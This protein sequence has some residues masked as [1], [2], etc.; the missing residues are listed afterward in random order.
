MSIYL[1]P[2]S[3]V[4]T[5]TPG[6][7]TFHFEVCVSKMLS[8]TASQHKG[9]GDVLWSGH[10]S[11]H[12]SK[13][14]NRSIWWRMYIYIESFIYINDDTTYRIYS[15]HQLDLEPTWASFSTEVWSMPCFVAVLQRSHQ[16]PCES[17]LVPM[18]SMERA[19]NTF[20]LL[21]FDLSMHRV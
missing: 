3:E 20:L 4:R 19:S 17:F 14:T 11:M 8:F 12:I 18:N 6:P 10:P 2:F 1:Y 5:E 15:T 13:G 9:V 16:V 21:S 7:T